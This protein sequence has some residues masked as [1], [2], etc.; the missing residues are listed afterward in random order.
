MSRF[1]WKVDFASLGLLDLIQAR[2]THYFGV[3]SFSS[4]S[5]ASEKTDGGAALRLR[6]SLFF[7][8]TPWRD[9]CGIAK[10]ELV[11]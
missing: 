11:A 5:Q 2:D 3:P 7:Q 4:P 9:C 10:K 6:G 8:I 1:T